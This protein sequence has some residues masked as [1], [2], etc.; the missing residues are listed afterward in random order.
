VRF[1]YSS[2]HLALLESECY[3]FAFAFVYKIEKLTHIAQ[4]VQKPI[5]KEHHGTSN[6]QRLC[7]MKRSMKGN[8][9]REALD[10]F[11][12]VLVHR[13]STFFVFEI[14]IFDNKSNN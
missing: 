12:C 7:G 5:C 11:L 13:H 3:K 8:S 10:L 6:L 1:I 9:K 14:N 4:N 2:G